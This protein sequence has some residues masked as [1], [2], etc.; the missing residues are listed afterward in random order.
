[1]NFN[2]RP[3]RNNHRKTTKYHASYHFIVEFRRW[4]LFEFS[5]TVWVC[6]CICIDIAVAVVGVSILTRVRRRVEYV[7]STTGWVFDKDQESQFDAFMLC[8]WWEIILWYHRAIKT[9]A[10]NAAQ[11]ELFY[12]VY[13]VCLIFGLVH[14][15]WIRWAHIWQPKL[16]L[17]II[18]IWSSG[19]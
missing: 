14:L 5:F 3:I 12:F 9:R 16:Y 4:S 1:M 13:F 6:V 7:G 10:A 8:W 15:T 19:R 2:S 18:L 17:L 11:F